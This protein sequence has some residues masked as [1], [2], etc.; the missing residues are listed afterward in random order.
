MQLLKDHFYSHILTPY[1]VHVNSYSLHQTES[2]LGIFSGGVEKRNGQDLKFRT[3]SLPGGSE[4]TIH[5][6]YAVKE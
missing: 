2:Y 1:V 3:L 6:R 5:W 4:C